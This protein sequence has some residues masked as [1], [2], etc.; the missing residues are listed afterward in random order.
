[1]L[2]ELVRCSSASAPSSSS[3]TLPPLSEKEQEYFRLG[4]EFYARELKKCK[5]LD[6]R[7]Y[8]DVVGTFVCFVSYRCIKCVGS[9]AHW[10]VLNL[11][12]RSGAG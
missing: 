7:S 10:R 3:S 11:V 5:P 9:N 1:M 6:P 2:H 12:A 8:T 4:E